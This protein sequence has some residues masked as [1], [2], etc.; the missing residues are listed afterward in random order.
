MTWILTAINTQKLTRN[1]KQ[2]LFVVSCY[3]SIVVVQY[4][5]CDQPLLASTNDS[6]TVKY[7]QVYL[8]YFVCFNRC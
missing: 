4:D 7:M 8:A 1:E 5:T 3:I 2:F 6:I